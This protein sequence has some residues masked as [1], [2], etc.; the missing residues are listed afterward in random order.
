MG[1]YSVTSETTAATIDTFLQHYGTESP[2]GISIQATLENLQ[3]ELRVSGCPL[4]YDYKTWAHLATNSYI[5]SL[6]GKVDHFGLG[7]QLE[8]KPLVPSQ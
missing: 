2:V 3:I 7:L 5:K 6:W 4:H 1:L 8:Y